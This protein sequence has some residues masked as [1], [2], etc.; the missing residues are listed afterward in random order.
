VNIGDQN[1]SWVAGN[2]FHPVIAKNIYRL[3]TD[4]ARPGGRFEQ[5]G[6]SWLKHGFTAH[7]QS[8]FCSCENPGTGSLLGKGC[9]DP[10]S[11]SLN[12]GSDSNSLDR[13]G[14]RSEVNAT[15]GFFTY[16]FTDISHP[17]ADD[18][19]IRVAVA[20]LEAT[21]N[22]DVRYFGEAQY[23]ASDDA[24]ARNGLNN[25][26]FRELTLDASA[27]FTW[28]GALG[29]YPGQRTQEAI[30]AWKRIDG[31]VEIARVDYTENSL[32]ARFNLA[33]K[34]HDNGDGTWRY[35]YA[36]H[37][38]NS[39]RSSHQFVVS[40]PPGAQITDAGFKDIDHHSGEP[41]ATDAWDIAVDTVAGTVTWGTSTFDSNPNAN[42]L[43]WGTMFNFWFDADQP[44]GT[45]TATVHLFRAGGVGEPVSLT[46]QTAV[47]GADCLYCDTFESGDT[48]RWSGAY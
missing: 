9:S 46:A 11:A 35:E 47:P 10:Y 48:L 31:E 38:L 22:P 14:P 6:M 23:I 33:A 16:P 25:A 5:V 7:A 30:R 42:A 8:E 18:Q 2:R 19:R 43:R 37:N 28:G 20:D 27:N 21:T 45:G 12:A 15:S 41:Y 3:K 13:L 39:H 44:P 40:F 34:V 17:Q 26:S 1:L 29:I 4:A 36:L 32:P 24:E